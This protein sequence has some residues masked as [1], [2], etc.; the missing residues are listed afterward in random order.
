[1]DH[2]DRLFINLKVVASILPTQKLNTKGGE[3]LV[4]E[5]GYWMSPS[6]GR[7]LR[8]D[9]R[10]NTVKRLGEV[11]GE[12]ARL[13]HDSDSES[14]RARLLAQLEATALGLK[15]LRQT[16]EGDPTIAAHFD[17]LLDKLAAIK[18]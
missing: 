14:L 9:G 12:A 11:I 18:S 15:N 7:W 8:D 1:M 16:Y 2:V 3:N 13:H 10:L 6:F 4:I 17:V 5:T